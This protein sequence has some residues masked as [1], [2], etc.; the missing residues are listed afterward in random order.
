MREQVKLRIDSVIGMIYEDNI[1]KYFP[2]SSMLLL[3]YMENC[4]WKSYRDLAERHGGDVKEIARYLGSLDGCTIYQKSRDRYLIAVNT[5]RK[6][7][8]LRW[9]TAHEI[10]H[11]LA[12]HFTELGVSRLPKTKLLEREA[13][14]FAASFLAPLAMI[15]ELR[16]SNPQELQKQ[17]GLSRTAAAWRWAS[18]GP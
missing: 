17:F 1:V 15:Y 3:P 9:T 8:R 6:F 14:Y 10:G 16:I 4:G 18:S 13:D 11:I 7:T 12:G 5:D 2:T